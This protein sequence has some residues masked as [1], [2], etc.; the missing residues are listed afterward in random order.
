MNPNEETTPTTSDQRAAA[1]R[2]RR[3]DRLEHG[4]APM[5]KLVQEQQRANDADRKAKE[6]W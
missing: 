6:G 1:R 2:L 3:A 4:T 5:L